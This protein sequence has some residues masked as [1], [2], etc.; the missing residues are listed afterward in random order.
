MKYHTKLLP[1]LFRRAFFASPKTAPNIKD[2][3]IKISIFD[4]KWKKLEREKSGTTFGNK[5]K[6]Y[7]WA[8]HNFQIYKYILKIL[9]L[10]SS[11]KTDF[12]AKIKNTHTKV[13]VA[14]LHRI[15]LSEII[16]ISDQS[17]D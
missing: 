3:K 14:G 6:T 17:I 2:A 11:T 7:S 8:S 10:T 1:L 15:C 9:E 13:R 12:I 5:R 4:F 16:I